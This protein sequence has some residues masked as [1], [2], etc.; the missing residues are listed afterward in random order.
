MS[1]ENARA[2]SEARAHNQNSAIFFGI[3]W[4]RVGVAHVY[5]QGSVVTVVRLECVCH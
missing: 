3:L 1:K 4:F 2:L 5:K